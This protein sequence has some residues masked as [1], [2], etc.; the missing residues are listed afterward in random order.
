MTLREW[1]RAKGV[2]VMEMAHRLDVNYST[3]VRWESGA[4]M[5]VDKALMA[6]DVLAIPIED[7]NFLQENAT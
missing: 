5:P 6:C 4:K 2:S 3:I 1:R 7:V